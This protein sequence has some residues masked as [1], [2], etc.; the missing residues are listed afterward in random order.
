MKI[1]N[2]KMLMVMP[3]DGG[4]PA[5]DNMSVQSHNDDMGSECSNVN[6]MQSE[7]PVGEF[8]ASNQENVVSGEIQGQRISRR[9][10]TPSVKWLESLETANKALITDDEAE[11]L[12]V[13]EALS[14]ESKMEW[15]QAIKDELQSLDENH[16]WKIV[17]KQ[18]DVNIVKCKFIFKNKRD[19]KGNIARRKARLVA[20][21][22]SQTEGVDYN[23]IFSPVVKYSS[24]RS[25]LASC[26]KE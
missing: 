19:S 12:T 13:K 16:T 22:F 24:I 18:N 10:I 5:N 9:V 4:N 6:D 11:P 25:A 3:T 14:S 7:E 26:S 2:L 17:P 1:A 23:E 15:E 20:K 21:G 8:K